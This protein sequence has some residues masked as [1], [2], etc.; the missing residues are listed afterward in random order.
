MACHEVLFLANVGSQAQ[1][2]CSAQRTQGF[3][4][5]GFLMVTAVTHQ[6]GSSH[7]L[8][9][10]PQLSLFWDLSYCEAAHLTPE[11]V[12]VPCEHLLQRLLAQASQDNKDQPQP[13]TTASH[14]GNWPRHSSTGNVAEC[15]PKDR[16]LMGL[17]F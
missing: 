10:E 4:C 13:N 8:S 16:A 3:V 12:Q 5:D 9:P 15:A 17:P 7:W 2:P 14:D 6:E 1:A 11:H